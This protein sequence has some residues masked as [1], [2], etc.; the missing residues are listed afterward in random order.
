MYHPTNIPS[1]IPEVHAAEE[2]PPSDLPNP[3]THRPTFSPELVSL[4]LFLF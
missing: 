1:V 3:T 4:S 2:M